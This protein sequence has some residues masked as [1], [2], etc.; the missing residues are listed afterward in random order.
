MGRGTRSS[1][2]LVVGTVEILDIRIALIE[3]EVEIAA[4]V[5]AHQEAGEHIAFPI[6]CPALTYLTTL[7]LHLLPNTPVNDRLMH[8]FEHNPV[9]TVVVNALFVFVG[10]GVC[11]EIENIAAILLQGQ[12]LGNRGAVPLRRRLLFALSGPLDALLKPVG[13]R[14][15]YFFPFELGGNLLRSK[16]LQGHTVNPLYDQ[17]ASSSMIHRFGLSGSFM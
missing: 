12:D 13:A 8:I 17:A 15:E 4:T 3:M 16:P 9:F 1:V 2:A 14:G 6:V 11:F 5:S 10:F 7:L